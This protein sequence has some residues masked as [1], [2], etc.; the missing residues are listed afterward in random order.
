MMSNSPFNRKVGFCD[1]IVQSIKSRC[2]KEHG[3]YHYCREI[4]ISREI[5]CV[6]LQLFPGNKFTIHRIVHI[7]H[8]KRGKNK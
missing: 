7:S 8:A 5:I 1:T 4:C 2:T 6:N 3:F